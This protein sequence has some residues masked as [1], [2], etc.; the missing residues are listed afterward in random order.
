MLHT[1]ALCAML[2]VT[3]CVTEF[4]KHAVHVAL[5]VAAVTP[6]YVSAKQMLQTA[7]P[8]VALYVPGMHAEHAPSA[9]TPSGPVYPSLHWHAVGTALAA[10]DTEFVLQSW[11]T[12]DDAFSVVEY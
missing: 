3:P 6:L 8:R 9:S 4:A 11:H 5:D 12:F 7:G 10:G 2:P 1:H